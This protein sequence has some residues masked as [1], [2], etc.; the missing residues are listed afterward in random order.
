MVGILLSFWN[1][2]F[3]GAMLVSGR[4]DIEREMGFT[5]MKSALEIY[6]RK[7]HGCQAIQKKDVCPMHFSP[8]LNMMGYFSTCWPR[9]ARTHNLYNLLGFAQAGILTSLNLCIGYAN[10]LVWKKS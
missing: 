4:E 9:V 3:S 2:L 7:V 1:G 6:R 10:L 8:L 5:V